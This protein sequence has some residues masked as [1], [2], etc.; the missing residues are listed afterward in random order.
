MIRSFLAV[1]V[2]VCTASPS[3]K[4][5]EPLPFE[6]LP[7][8]RVVYSNALV[9]RVN[10]VGAQDQFRVGYRYRLYDSESILFRTGYVGVDTSA[11]ITPALVRLGAS[12]E[13]E[14]I[15]VLQLGAK[16]E[17]VQYY[18]TI[19][20]LQSFADTD[21]N[22]SD[23]ENGRRSDAGLNDAR[24]GWQASA[25]A[26]LRARVGP[27]VIRSKVLGLYA[28]MSLRDG[29]SVWYDPYYDLLAPGTGWTI[30]NDAD[31]LLFLLQDRL[32]VGVRHNT[33]HAV[34]DTGYPAVQRMGPLVA[35]R[36]MDQ[37]GE[38][39]GRATAFVLINWYLS[40]PFRTGSDVHQAIPYVAV[41]FAL[42]GDLL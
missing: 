13:V 34:H 35:Y 3:A 27:L 21:V 42:N 40:H 17:W 2:L 9:L 8:H 12:L 36:F 7:R 20:H 29:T 32:I 4:S 30:I 18:G 14:P 25:Y 6:P 38:V 26:T 10:P 23:T 33:S 31:L 37:P 24:G 15:A 39:L 11:V 5:V 19:D 16:W 22:W 28:D 1:L 41:G